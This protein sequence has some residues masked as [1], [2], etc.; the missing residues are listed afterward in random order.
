[1]ISPSPWKEHEKVLLSHGESLEERKIK[2]SLI[3]QR[4]WNLIE[5]YSSWRKLWR[6][7]ALIFRFVNNCRKPK[8]QRN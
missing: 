8:I 7:T 5:N 3:V 4:E 2:Y 6:I 1:M